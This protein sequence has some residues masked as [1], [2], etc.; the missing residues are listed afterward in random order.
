[1]VRFLSKIIARLAEKEKQVNES[2]SKFLT[3][4]LFSKT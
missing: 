2:V 3:Q 1:M 4:I